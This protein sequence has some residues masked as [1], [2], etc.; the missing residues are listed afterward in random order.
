[1]SFG[2]SKEL[3]AVFRPEKWEQYQHVICAP[4]NTSVAFQC[5][6][7]ELG[8]HEAWY[9]FQDEIVARDFWEM[10]TDAGISYDGKKLAVG[11]MGPNGHILVNGERFCEA[12][13]DTIHHMEWLDNDRVIYDAWNDNDSRTEEER[14]ERKF[15]HHVFINDQDMGGDD[16]RDKMTFEP[17]WSD[18]SRSLITIHVA[19]LSK[20]MR[21]RIDHLGRLSDPVPIHSDIDEASAPSIFT[22]GRVLEPEEKLE[23]PE[24]LEHGLHQCVV[25][26]GIRGQVF[27]EI[28]DGPGN[29]VFNGDH[30]RVA[31]IGIKYKR[32]A[33]MAERAAW[34]I[35]R[36]SERLGNVGA[37]LSIPIAGLYS[38][39]SLLGFGRMW[40]ENSKVFFPATQEGSW[41]KGWPWAGQ[42]FFTP[43]GNLVATVL[44]GSGMRVVVDEAEG[45]LFDQVHHPVYI[46]EEKAVT[47]IGQKGNSFYRVTI[48]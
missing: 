16:G 44:D 31:Y 15:D 32:P 27:H 28:E 2:H 30:S 34:S 4:N 24:V 6:G 23:Y 19:N 33:R 43:E 7:P 47:Y 26:K 46:L 22:I 10:M 9:V 41:K 45:D 25:Y 35:A 12:P 48:S 38:E 1:M 17:C 20:R 37:I 40:L 11:V 36:F 29:F 3:I 42:Q 13:F 39:Q 21:W 14:D 8:S 5:G 18:F